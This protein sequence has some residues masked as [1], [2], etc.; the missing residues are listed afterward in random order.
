[1]ARIKI[2]YLGGGSTRAAGTMASFL[3]GGADFDGSEVV[4]IDLEPERLDLIHRLAVKMAKA[5][6]LDITIT[7]TTDRRAGVTDCDAILSSFRPGG[8][9][10]RVQDERIPMRHDAIGQET[11]GPGGFFMALRSVNVMKGLAEDLEAVAPKAKVFNYTNPVNIVAQAWTRNC[12]I[13]FVSLCEGPIIFAKEL[14]RGAGLDYD[15]AEARMIGL[16]HGCWSVSGTYDGRDLVAVLRERYHEVKDD[17]AVSRFTKRQLELVDTMGTVGAYYFQYYYFEDEVVAELQA[18]ET[19]RAEDILSWSPGYWDHYRAQVET[20]DPQLDPARS[21]GGIHELELAIDVMDAVFNGKDE[22][23]PVNLPNTGQVLAELPAD[24]VVE[25][26]GRT[27]GGW[28]DVAPQPALP[29]HVVGLVKALGE[30]QY[31]AGDAAWNGTRRDAIRALTANPLVRTLERA[32]AM[33]DEL[34]A[35]HAAYL[36]DRLR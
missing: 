35:A 28:I 33:Y 20:D 25:V 11:Q 13:P 10:A 26:Y 23:H 2:A 7:A 15:K 9:E 29:R 8:F 36:P 27:T 17:P 24:L 14:A 5:R 31:L 18:K 12:D 34:A 21:R 3:H 30:Y 6:G 16:N 4:L 22:T 1:V 32:T 19:T